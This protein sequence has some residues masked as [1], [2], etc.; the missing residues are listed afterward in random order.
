MDKFG[1]ILIL[2]FLIFACSSETEIIEP[3]VC[4]EQEILPILNSNCTQSGCHNDVDHEK[5]FIANQYNHILA[6]VKPG[7]YL[8]SKL[9][10]LM[11]HPIPSLRMPPSPENALSESDIRIIALW[12]E[13]GAKNNSCTPTGCDT[14]DVSF[15]N[16]ISPIIRRNCQGC[17]SG[18]NPQGG[19]SLTNYQEIV[20]TVDNATLEGTITW[21]PG[22]SPMPK[23]ANQLS[24]CNIQLIKKWISVGAPNN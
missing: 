23:N 5:G 22:Y 7:N 20:K 6:E 24:N 19:V 15:F 11:I 4:F 18:K 13:Q 3:E 21:E 10:Q 12:I 9:Y 14:S 2:S 8:S 17:H 1:I 16:D